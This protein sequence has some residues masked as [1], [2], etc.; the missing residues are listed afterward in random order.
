MVSHLVE[1]L[2]GEVVEGVGGDGAHVVGEYLGRSM[3]RAEL[4]LWLGL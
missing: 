2:G 3:L 4:W 1:V